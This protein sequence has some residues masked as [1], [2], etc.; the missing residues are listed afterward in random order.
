MLSSWLRNIL[1]QII[2]EQE[3]GGEP[4]FTT[5]VLQQI[6]TF[7]GNSVQGLAASFLQRS[8]AMFNQQQETL[9]KQMNQTLQDNP[10]SSVSEM[11]QRNLELWRRMQ[12][13]FFNAAGMGTTPNAENAKKESE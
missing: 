4:I 10:L 9:Q 7:Y 2:I 5:D 12:N 8:L 3:D 6:I 11:T 1:L 13:D